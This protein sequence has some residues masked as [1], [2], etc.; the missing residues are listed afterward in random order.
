MKKHKERIHFL[1]RISG[2]RKLFFCLLLGIL[3]FVLMSIFKFDL[4]NKI[5]LSWDTF[6]LTMIVLSAIL[7]FTTSED[8]LV[9]VV[10][11]QDEDL[12]VIFSLVLVSVGVSLFGAI[13]ILFNKQSEDTNKVL[14]TLI[15]ISPVFLSWFQL[16]TI[17]AIRYAH[18]YNDHNRSHAGSE[19]LDFPDNKKPDYMDFAY[20]SFVI[21]MTFQVSD[22]T[23]NSRILR[24]FVLLH[25]IISFGYNTLIIA[26]TINTISS[27]NS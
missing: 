22:V 7:F 10:E 21:G 25:S 8:E 27:L 3:V 1:A 15:S 18:L 17:F 5:I 14:Q 11:R 13:I 16:H 9:Q 26:L 12:K 24:R 20:F 6:C 19:G 23:I 2:L 4:F